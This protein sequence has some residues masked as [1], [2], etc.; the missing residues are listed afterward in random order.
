LV[1]PNCQCTDNNN[2]DD[3]GGDDENEKDVLSLTVGRMNEGSTLEMLRRATK[4]KRMVMSRRL[5]RRLLLL[6][7]KTMRNISNSNIHRPVQCRT[8]PIDATD[9]NV[10]MIN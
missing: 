1:I 8:K 5:R 10:S 4:K 7:I 9:G 6:P 2:N 3:G